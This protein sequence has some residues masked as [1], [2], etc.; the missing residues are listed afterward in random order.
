MSC[1]FGLLI[2]ECILATLLSGMA[3]DWCL[4][5]EMRLLIVR[6]ACSL[7][8]P[9]VIADFISVRSALRTC[10][11]EFAS[12]VDLHPPFW[13]R[14]IC[15]PRTPD[16]H[17]SEVVRRSGS[18]P[19]ELVFRFTESDTEGLDD[20]S[21]WEVRLDLFMSQALPMLRPIFS[22]CAELSVEASNGQVSYLLL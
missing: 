4:S 9:Y 1:V 14:M 13:N 15:S 2:S 19:M 3:L 17:V 18:L 5:K 20:G 6:Q 8:R 12:I 22:L 7:R 21:S 16:Q 11:K 10:S